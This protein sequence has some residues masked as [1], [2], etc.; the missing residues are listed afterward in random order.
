MDKYGSARAE[1]TGPRLDA[2]IDILSSG[3]EGED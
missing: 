3:P 1:L 2:L